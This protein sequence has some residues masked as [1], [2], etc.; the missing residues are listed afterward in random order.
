MA[1]QKRVIEL[2]LPRDWMPDAPMKRIHAHWTAG[3]HEP[4]ATD[5]KHY[6][7]LV[8]GSGDIRRGRFPISAN[9]GAMPR[10]TYA[11]HT[12]NA[13]S[14]A[15]GVSMCCMAGAMERPL[16]YGTDPMTKIQWDR[17]I[18]TIAA[19][20]ARY[21]IPVTPKTILSHAEVQVNLGIAQRQKWDI[22]VLPFDESIRGA[23]AIG[24]LMRRQ[25]QEL[26]K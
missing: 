15:I 13:N 26:L 20:A 5:L 21:K 23:R 11:A 14:G 7:L 25:V 19:L 10:G 4:N 1:D 18:E 9:T 16:R 24:D 6:H 12:L 22:T 2:I 8:T 17:M 3:N